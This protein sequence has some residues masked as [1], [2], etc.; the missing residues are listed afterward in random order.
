MRFNILTVTKAAACLVPPM[1]AFSI[2]SPGIWGPVLM[3]VGL[4]AVHEL[5]HFLAAK[6]MGMR[7]EVFSVGFG[8]RLVGFAWG[9]T[10]VRLSMLPLGGYVKLAGYNPEEPDAEDPYGFLKQ[11][12]WKRIVFYSGGVV[13]NAVACAALIYCVGI[14]RERWPSPSLVLQVQEGSAAEAGGLLTGDV[15]RRVGDME[16]PGASWNNEIVPYIRSHPEVGVPVQVQRDGATLDFTVTPRRQGQGGILGITAAPGPGE[17]PARPLQ[18]HDFLA[19]A[20]K[21]LEETVGIGGLVLKSIWRLVTLQASVKDVGGPIAI[22]KAGSDAAKAGWATYFLMTA[23]ISINLAVLNLLPIP[24]LDGGHICIL[25][26]E[27]LRRRDLTIAVK[28]KIMATG[29]YF[30]AT[31]MALVIFLDLM[32]LKQ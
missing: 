18:F 20:P 25:A 9:E 15:L 29:F 8:P 11:P 24:F 27:R 30:M 1:M 4:I 3:L 21:A 32:R 19:A 31:V 2:F 23:F 22:V 14:D 5:G 13:A 7:V 16:L 12:A 6:A 17:G 10:D 28:E 26:F